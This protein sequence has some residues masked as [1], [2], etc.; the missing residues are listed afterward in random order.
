MQ[1]DAIPDWAIYIFITP[2]F[3]LAGVIHVFWGVLQMLIILGVTVRR[4]VSSRN[5]SDIRL[6]FFLR[7]YLILPNIAVVIWGIMTDP[8]L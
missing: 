7:V 3:P 6:R 1:A 4:V 5:H 2:L 8:A